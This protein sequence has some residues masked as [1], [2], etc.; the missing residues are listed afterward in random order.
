MKR[1][2]FVLFCLAGF[3]GACAHR[4]AKIIKVDTPQM[5]LT[6][7][8]IM[9][10]FG[11]A[12]EPVGTR[13]S[14]ALIFDWL[15][16]STSQTDE[17][18]LTLGA[19]KDIQIEP[20]YTLVSLEAPQE[21]FLEAW[22][23]L[24]RRLKAPAFRE[25]Y[26]EPIKRKLIAA[27]RSRLFA[28]LSLFKQFSYSALYSGTP[29]ANCHLGIENEILSLSNDQAKAIYQKTF[30]KGPA[31]IFI[32][33]KGVESGIESAISK[34]TTGWAS[35]LKPS[36]SPNPLIKGR[37]VVIV[38][39]PGS[40]EAYLTFVKAS[41]EANTSDYFYTMLA[42]EVLGGNGGN[43]SILGRALRQEKS[44]TYHASLQTS[45]RAHRPMILGLTF[46]PNDKIE[47][48]AKGY[49]DLWSSFA[50]QEF[51]N[52]SQ[53]ELAEKVV[54][55]TAMRENETLADIFKNAAEVYSVSGSRD[56][57][58][59]P[60]SI[61]LKRFNEAKTKWLSTDDLKIVAIGDRRVL[62]TTL[63]KVFGFGSKLHI[64]PQ[65]ADWE[66]INDAL[67]NSD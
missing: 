52:L 12:D 65:N 41:P 43:A 47:E 31:V 66:T 40:K 11:S 63:V 33:S 5:P 35:T 3:L 49:L 51:T 46:G 19:V 56:F 54:K 4:E 23:G 64:L 44:L 58:W 16:A 9:F 15:L 67:T 60:E 61:D 32:P 38:D 57:P 29:E 20:H 10:P 25:D 21:H 48:L 37:H 27:K 13:G 50:K 7:A 39:R 59:K 2:S 8:G 45:R 55:S 34:S 6:R 24:I 17:Q 36:K 28:P 18:M 1:V 22:A 26:F 42:T 62:A 30:G 14:T 53:L